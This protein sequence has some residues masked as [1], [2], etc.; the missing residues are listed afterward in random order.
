MPHPRKPQL[1]HCASFDKIFGLS[2]G[3]TIAVDGLRIQG[4][5][6]V[7]GPVVAYFFFGL[8]K[9]RMAGAGTGQ[10]VGK[11]AIGF[12]FKLGGTTIANLGDTLNSKGIGRDWLRTFSCSRSGGAF[13]KIRWTKTKRSTLSGSYPRKS[14]FHAITTARSYGKRTSIPPMIDISKKASKEWELDAKY[15][16]METRFCFSCKIFMLKRICVV[17]PATIHLQK[18]ETQQ[19]SLGSGYPKIHTHNTLKSG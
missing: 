14:S 16:D 2:A 13:R 19:S 15:W 1:Y 8:V 5:K 10:Q 7:H 18:D 6:S 9:I 11:G 12:H 4:L 3:K 17:L